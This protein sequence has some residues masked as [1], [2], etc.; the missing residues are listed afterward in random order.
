MKNPFSSKPNV[1]KHMTNKCLNDLIHQITPDVGGQIGNWQFLIDG[2]DILVITHE[3]YNRM[4]I[5]SPITSTDRLNAEALAR[6]LEANFS[7]ALDAK[8]AIR[9]E[10]LWSVFTH[11]LAE[12]TEEQ[13]L[14]CVAQ[15]ANLANN[16]GGTYASSNLSFGKR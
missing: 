13:F 1:R 3:R 9:D 11:P 16:F 10:T 15:V 5:I 4:R 6:L 8:Y 12:L 14:D 7:S 2:R